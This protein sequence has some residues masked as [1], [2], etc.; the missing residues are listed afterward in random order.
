MDSVQVKIFR[1][2]NVKEDKS[3][4]QFT[5]ELVNTIPKSLR[6]NFDLEN[7]DKLLNEGIN[8]LVFGTFLKKLSAKG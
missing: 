2:K 6:A 8:M 5:S 4:L 3:E 1:E 7:P